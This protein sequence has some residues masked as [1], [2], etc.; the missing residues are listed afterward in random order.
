MHANTI[1]LGGGAIEN[2]PGLRVT[3]HDDRHGWRHL[4][5]TKDKPVTT[6]VDFPSEKER[7]ARHRSKS[8]RRLFPDGKT[9][10][11]ADDEMMRRRGIVAAVDECQ[12][13]SCESVRIFRTEKS[14]PEISNDAE[15]FC[16]S[17]V[18][19]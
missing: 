7:I 18:V 12:V 1:R 13:R 5:L 9:I 6:V 11:I 19:M 2:A 10:N 16:F 3:I 4:E 8:D 14:I 17:T 15:F